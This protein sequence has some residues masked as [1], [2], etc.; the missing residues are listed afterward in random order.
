MGARRGSLVS[1]LEEAYRVERTEREWLAE[2]VRSVRPLLE[3]G[4]GIAAYTYDAAER[5]LSVREVLL[6]CPLDAQGLSTVLAQSNESYVE[7]AWLSKSVATASE[8]PGYAQHPGV[9]EVFHPVG[10]RDVL[11][12]N[13]LDVS[14]IGC[15]L[16]A[17]L[18]RETRVE[19]RVRERLDRV[20]AHLRA[21]L[22]LRVRLGHSLESTEDARSGRVEA[23]FER[24][25]RVAHLERD[26]EGAR[27]DLRRAVRDVERARGKLRHRPDQ[28]MASWSTLV[29]A[30]WS[31][32]DDFERGGERYVVARANATEAKGPLSLTERERQIVSLLAMGH[33]SKVIA[34]ELGLSDATVRVL[35][36]R[37]Q[38]RLG[39]TG[40]RD[41][42]TKFR[43]LSGG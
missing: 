40:R 42:V 41:L 3:D 1:V 28:A 37:A 32:V 36:A 6:D 31:I 20:T 11:V 16:G 2:L 5:P 9:R 22:R 12:V 29:R 21:A 39:A 26:A 14:G 17:P 38:K 18:P 10:I 27:D 33:T 34:Y 19:P 25:G 43:A 15:L 35:V 8:T 4:L 30:R 13:A 23:V 7:G 24:D